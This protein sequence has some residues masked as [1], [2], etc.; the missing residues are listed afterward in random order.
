[1]DN[2]QISNAYALAKLLGCDLTPSEFKKKYCEYFNEAKKEY[3]SE[4]PS[5]RTVISNESPF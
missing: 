3:Q 4:Q 5:R 2:Q 1:M